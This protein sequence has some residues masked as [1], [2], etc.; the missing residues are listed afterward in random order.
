MRGRATGGGVLVPQ[1]K[2][3]M[4]TDLGETMDRDGSVPGLFCPVD[5]K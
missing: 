3:T 1:S 5:H 4:E 2:R